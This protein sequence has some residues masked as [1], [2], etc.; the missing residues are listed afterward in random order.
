MDLS[1]MRSRVREDLQDEDAANYIFTNDQVDGAIER[2]VR[3][4]SW[5]MPIEEEDEITTT[6]DSREV[7]I[8]SLTNLL[9]VCSIEYPMDLTPKFMQRLERWGGKV[10]MEDE[11]DGTNK[12]RVRW[13]KYHTLSGAAAW[14]ANTAYALGDIVVPTTLNGYWYECTTA[15]TSHATTEPTWPTTVGGTVTDGTVT[16]TCRTSEIPFEYEEIIVLGATG[17]LAMSA[18]AYTIDRANV[19]GNAASTNFASWGKERLERYRKQLKAI[20]RSN[21]IIGSVLYTEDD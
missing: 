8:T 15:G 4:F 13:Y 10:Y 5:A 3:E 19:A 12:A 17:Y 6:A 11:G 14:V 20:S 7:T 18:S 21:R 9:K 16:W 2:V 1:T